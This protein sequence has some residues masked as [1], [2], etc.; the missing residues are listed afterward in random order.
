MYFPLLREIMWGSFNLLDLM[1][2]GSNSDHSTVIKDSWLL[3]PDWVLVAISST[4]YVLTWVQPGRWKRTIK[5]ITERERE[6]EQPTLC[7]GRRATQLNRGVRSKPHLINRV[8]GSNCPLTCLGFM[9]QST[10]LFSTALIH[11]AMN[12]LRR[13]GANKFPFWWEFNH[14][15]YLVK[16][17][18]MLMHH[19]CRSWSI[20]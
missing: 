5:E 10:I 9:L 6:R 8:C 4:W 1:S 18:N 3:S 14:C 20:I 17:P 13:L 12:S 16:T 2:S 19:K 15:M 7:L 11:T